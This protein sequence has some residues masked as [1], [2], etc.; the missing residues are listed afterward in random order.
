MSERTMFDRMQSAAMLDIP[1]YEEVEADESATGQAGMVVLI[2]ALSSAIG[3]IGG[4]LGGALVGM[5]MAL[6]GWFLYAGVT[7]FIGT[8]LFKGTATW[9]EVLRTTGFAQAPN[10]LLI[11]GII[12][13]LGGLIRIVIS[14]WVLVCV[15]IGIRQALDI[16]T[17]P[18]IATGCLAAIVIW[19]VMAAVTL[20]LLGTGAVLGVGS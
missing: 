4:G 7:Y 14:I 9:G 17:G 2:G 15:V 13:L 12:P 19:A 8:S 6:V 1:T 11:L 5:V 18:A 3:G 16:E 10:A 20:L